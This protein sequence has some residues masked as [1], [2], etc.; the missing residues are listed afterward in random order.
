MPRSVRAAVGGY[1]YRVINRGNARAEVFYADV[2][3]RK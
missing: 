3:K 1:C 2:G